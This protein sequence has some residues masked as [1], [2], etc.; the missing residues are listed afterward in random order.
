MVGFIVTH[1]GHGLG[2]ILATD[3]GRVSVSFLF[4]P[5]QLTLVSEIDGKPVLRR[6]ILPLRTP[7]E[8]PQGRCTILEQHPASE[9]SAPH[10]Y[11]VEYDDGL[12]AKVSETELEPVELLRSSSP[13]EVLA[14]LELDG[15]GTFR[16]REALADQWLHLVQAGRGVKAL[17]SSRIDLRPHQTYVAGTV[18]LDRR[19]RYLL[20]DEV[21][22]G[23]TIEAGIVIHDLLQKKPSANILIICPDA[24]SQQWLCELYAK[25]SGKV[26]QMLELHGRGFLTAAHQVQAIAPFTVALHTANSLRQKSWDL[27]VVDEAHHLL[28]VPKLYQTAKALS[29]S[30]PAF[31]LLSAVPARHRED[32]YLRLLALLE[33]ARYDPNDPQEKER[34]KLLYDRQVELSRKLSYI[35]RHMVD[36]PKKVVPK[37]LEL[38][39]FPVLT[40]DS[41][42]ASMAA[43]IMPESASFAADVTAL[44]HYV[45]DRYRINRRI[46]RN[47]RSQLLEAQPDLKIDRKLN[48]LPCPAD[49]LE[50]DA[51]AAVRGFLASLKAARLSEEVIVPLARYLLQAMADPACLLDFIALAGT[52]G[53]PMTDLLALDSQISYSGWT[54]YG[55]AL[56]GAVGRH[57]ASEEFRDCLHAI[58]KWADALDVPP[59]TEALLDFLKSRHRQTPKRKFLI[60]AGFPGLAT[61]LADALS[62]AFNSPLPVARFTSKMTSKAKEKEAHRFR[63]DDRCWLLVCDETGGEGR[64]FQF[65]DEL[66]HYDLPWHVAKIEQRIGRLDRLGRKDPEVW[67]NV[68]FSAGEE[69]EGLLACLESGFQIFSRSISGL[70]FTLR[71]IEIEFASVAIRD[72]LEGLLSL[73]PHIKEKVESERAADDVQAVLDAA[74]LNRVAAEAFRKAQSTPE[75]DLA[76]ERSFCNYFKFV[77]GDPAIRFLQVGDYPEGVVEFRPDQARRLALDLCPNP[78]HRLAD[79][80]GTFRR[81]IAQD[82]PDLEFF[83]VGNPLFDAVCSS[84]CSSPKG[85]TYA[86]ECRASHPQWRGFEFSYRPSGRKTLLRSY[87]GLVNHLDRVFAVRL[88]HCFIAEDLSPASDTGPLLTLR[89]SLRPQDHNSTWWNF[90]LNNQRI[91]LLQDRY[92]AAAWPVLLSKAEHKARELAR[93]RLAEALEPLFTAE[94]ARIA[95]QVRQSEAAKA[96]DW[97][98][99]VA[100]LNH[101]LRALDEWDLELDIVGFLSVNGG[102]V[103]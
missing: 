24:L 69:E 61:R 76:L 52:P 50:L 102:L 36:D 7:C 41:A 8:T 25:F 51:R 84:L 58:K 42:L 66:V 91:T 70:E 87:P 53:L 6:S 47:R 20:A 29:S 44:L 11:T 60:F 92:T 63:R 103:A 46:L 27:V 39:A 18:I 22:L 19:Q 55:S 54:E 83:S 82:N 57:S 35:S 73:V 81:A 79:H 32:E 3:N 49:Q 28:T 98:E 88:E 45:G 101:L 68:L 10:F 23:K 85:R 100:G 74:S 62:E 33:P 13:L 38:T 1:L 2:K 12:S 90:T 94:R 80:L 14:N 26:F 99:E 67:S 37:I 21:G 4:P 17:L 31:L 5:N 89:R 95:E 72:G 40:A 15:Y 48:R 93:T 86:I 71:E 78:D 96:D 9:N 43:R 64:N 34:F 65:A 75:R 59:R 30:A 16:M 77:A 56:W 97:Q